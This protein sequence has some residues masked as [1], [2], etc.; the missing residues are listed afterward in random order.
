MLKKAL[1]LAVAAA[2]F[3]AP[4][5]AAMPLVTDDTGTQGKGG[6]QLETGLERQRATV[7][8]TTTTAW[9][10]AA[11]LTFGLGDRVDLVA[12]VPWTLQTVEAAGRS[13]SD[14]G[15]G[16]LALQLKWRF[17]ELEEGRFSIAVKP[18][19]T[20]PAGNEEQGFGTGKVTAGALLIATHRGALGALHLNLGYT[21]NSYRIEA[22]EAASRKAIWHASVAGELQVSGTLR[23]IAD[24][25][26][27]TNRDSG[28]GTHP[29][30][31]LGGVIYSPSERLD[32]DL[33][34]KG[35]LNDAQPATSLLAGATMHL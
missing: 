8:G 28:K 17:A 19:I 26:L 32:L 16:D 29:A 34:V 10:S 18:C 33:G 15:I 11:A 30:Y 27:D 23:A 14:N 21:R 1:S 35:G 2:I 9:L 4:A 13:V 7:A 22:Q 6:L 25:G 31:L 3:S 20:I 12:G 5:F 24:S